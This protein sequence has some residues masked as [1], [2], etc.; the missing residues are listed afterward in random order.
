MKNTDITRTISKITED[1]SRRREEIEQ[2]QNKIREEYERLIKENRELQKERHILL[3][4]IRLLRDAIKENKLKL[5]LEAL[6]YS[7]TG[8]K[9]GEYIAQPKTKTINP[10]I[11]DAIISDKETIYAVKINKETK[12]IPPNGQNRQ[13]KTLLHLILDAT[14]KRDR[15]RSKELAEEL[16]ID[17]KTIKHWVDVM[18][19]RNMIKATYSL[20]GELII[21]KIK[22]SEPTG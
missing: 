16:N 14:K 9:F 20:G 5:E 3:E 13:I 8:E 22:L 15:I 21:E 7:I 1:I 17:E 18:A 6:H 19:K 11:K 2:K 4:E 10:E 12:K